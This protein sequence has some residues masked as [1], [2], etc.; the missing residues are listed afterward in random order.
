MKKGLRLN[1]EN[2]NIYWPVKMSYE[3]RQRG[4]RD[5]G[6]TNRRCHPENLK[7]KSRYLN[8]SKWS[9]SRSAKLRHKLR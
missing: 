9:I 7:T 3:V 8:R 4:S 6:E 2:L 5:T 1:L